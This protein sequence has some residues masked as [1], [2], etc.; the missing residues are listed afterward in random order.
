MKKKKVFFEPEGIRSVVVGVISFL[1]FK[2]IITSS[3]WTPLPLSN[4]TAALMM[5][6]MVW[7]FNFGKVWPWT[8]FITIIPAAIVI[9]LEIS[10]ELKDFY[11]GAALTIVLGFLGIWY[12]FLYA[13]KTMKVFWEV[14]GPDKPNLPRM[15]KFFVISLT[16]VL[17]I[18]VIATYFF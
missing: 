1:L 11:L 4:S 10:I 6:V 8:K 2:M 13:F 3:D 9:I 16:T 5:V 7:L 17:V 18:M 12:L 15:K 14:C